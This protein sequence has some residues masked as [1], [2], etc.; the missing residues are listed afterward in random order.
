MKTPS[1]RL[2][3]YLATGAARRV[4]IGRERLRQILHERGITF[5]RTR[6][7][8]ES[9]DPGKDAKLD[10]IK[11]VTSHFP[12]RCVSPSTSSVRSAT[13][14]WATLTTPSTLSW[15]AAARLPALA[16]R[17]RPPPRCTGRPT[18]RTRPHPQRTQATLGPPA[19]K[20]RLSTPAKVGLRGG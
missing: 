2:A 14:W 1:G 4:R 11:H 6:A 10:R 3:D 7:W 13:S 20:G 8:K 5:Q 17:Q 12:D 9:T 19:T 16:Q 15:P 18:A